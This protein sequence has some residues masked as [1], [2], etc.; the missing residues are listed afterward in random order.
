MEAE[1]F[2]TIALS[3]ARLERG[4]VHALC[5]LDALLSRLTRPLFPSE[6]RRQASET[7]SFP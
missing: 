7:L 2:A 4:S 6:D 5:L 3:R 1:G